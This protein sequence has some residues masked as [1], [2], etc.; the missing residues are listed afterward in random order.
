MWLSVSGDIAPLIQLQL[1]VT[2]CNYVIDMD[3]LS[4][5]GY[6]SMVIYSK[7]VPFY[8]DLLTISP[9]VQNIAD[10]HSHS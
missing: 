7:N 2:K 4:I 5:R 10:M 3:R 6:I 1:S 8:Y 9:V